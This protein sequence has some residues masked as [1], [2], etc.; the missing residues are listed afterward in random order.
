MPDENLFGYLPL[1]LHD[2]AL[3]CS[4]FW[5]CRKSTTVHRI[6]EPL[7][8]VPKKGATPDLAIAALPG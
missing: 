8:T 2:S 5:L 4:S 6:P 1:G 3:I 7:A